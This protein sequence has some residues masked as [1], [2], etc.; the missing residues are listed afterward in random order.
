M[1]LFYTGDLHGSERCFRKF[2]NAASFYE[3]D[4]LVLGGDITGKLL[5]P[6]VEEKPGRYVATVLGRKEKAK[7]PRDLAD[8]EKQ[9]RFNGFYPYRCTPDEYERL[10]D[11]EAFRDE[12]MSRV[13]VEEVSRWMSIADEKLAATVTQFLIMPGNDD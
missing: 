10:R 11:D 12:V 4:V 7:R 9:I 5:T 13:M 1:R 8:M 6:V 3:A 2:L